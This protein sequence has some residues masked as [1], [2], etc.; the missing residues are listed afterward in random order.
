M[1]FGQ[2]KLQRKAECA[3]RHWQGLDVVLCHGCC[4]FQGLRQEGKVSLTETGLAWLVLT[5]PCLGIDVMAPA[6]R[7]SQMAF[8]R[9]L[10]RLRVAC[11]Q[12]G[13]LYL[14]SLE[15]CALR[16]E[17]CLQMCSG[18]VKARWNAKTPRAD[19]VT[20]GYTPRNPT[21]RTAG[22]D[23]RFEIPTRHREIIF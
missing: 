20:Q 22:S 9:R 3:S 10:C 15:R 1:Q 7:A 16:D 6:I 21:R 8:W 13:Y 18:G 23:K 4:E 5:A 11:G 14:I 12:R 19:T 17:G 2:A